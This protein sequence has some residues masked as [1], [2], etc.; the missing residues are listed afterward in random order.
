MTKDKISFKIEIE[1]TLANSIRRYV[2]QI[3]IPAI[4]EVEISKND[5]PLYDETV[6]HRIGLIPLKS[7]KS[8]SEKTTGKIKLSTS[9][10]GY[11]YS[12]E[13]KGDFEPVYE[14]IPITLLNK[15]QEFEI[16]ATIKAGKGIEHAKFS[17]GAMFYKNIFDIKVD[18]DCPEEVVKLCSKKVLSSEKGKITATNP[19]K[20]DMCEVCSDYCQENGKIDSI[21][22]IPNHEYTITVESFGQISPEEIFKRSIE[23]LKKDLNETVKKIK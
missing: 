8:V 22:I 11:V 4:D 17:P 1:E 6:A 23:A 12:G 16:S 10:E 2:N 14:K 19:E 9:K 13:I 7:P 3:L 21:K 20:C 15:D 5:S 18:K